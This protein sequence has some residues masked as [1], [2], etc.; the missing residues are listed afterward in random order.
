MFDLP[1][2]SVALPTRVLNEDTPS[3]LLALTGVCT[4]A[5]SLI[6]KGWHQDNPL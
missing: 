3:I 2:P 4:E 5:Y 1:T 6:P